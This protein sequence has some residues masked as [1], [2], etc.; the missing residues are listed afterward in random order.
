MGWSK[1]G[2]LMDKVIV[3]A[4]RHVPESSR[5]EFFKEMID[6]FEY[7]DCD[8]LYESLDIDRY[9]N[10]AYESLYPEHYAEIMGSYK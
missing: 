2:E 9:Y 3:I 5:K 8:T 4:T 6:A 1:G 10:Q 7:F